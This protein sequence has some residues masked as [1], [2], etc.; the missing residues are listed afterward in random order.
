MALPTRA[1]GIRDYRFH[2]Q[3][4]QDIARTVPQSPEWTRHD[5]VA[6][7]QA[8][9]LHLVAL[10]WPGRAVPVFKVDMS[11]TGDLAGWTKEDR[12]LLIDEG[13]RQIDRQRDDLERIRSRSAFLLTTS[14]GL[15]AAAVA[16]ITRVSRDP[17]LAAFV[18]LAVGLLAVVVGLLG[19]ASL[20][21]AQSEIS[22]IHASLLSRQTSPIDAPTAL[23]YASMVRTGE[24]TV[25]TRLTLFRDATS[26]LVI[27][28]ILE[29]IAWFITL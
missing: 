9:L 19:A 1:H 3:F 10:F 2:L 23:A 20:L 17:S 11:T 26:L 18:V 25:A 6:E 29:T 16:V 8:Y 28:A 14:L 12:T 24:N 7:A 4:P 21:T 22:S 13:R 5:G 15:V 27:G